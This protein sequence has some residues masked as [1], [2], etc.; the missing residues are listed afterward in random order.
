MRR[1]LLILPDR[2][3]HD[4]LVRQMDVGAAGRLKK[5]TVPDAAAALDL[6]RNGQGIA[7]LTDVAAASAVEDG[8]VGPATVAGGGNSPHLLCVVA[9]EPAADLGGGGFPEP[10]G[11]ADAARG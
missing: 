4:S 3:V 10:A 9:T 8:C 1:Y 5:W 11:D 6:A 2:C 7:F